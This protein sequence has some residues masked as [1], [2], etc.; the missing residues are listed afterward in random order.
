MKTIFATN[1]IRIILKLL[2]DPTSTRR[3]GLFF[4]RFF[5]AEY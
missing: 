2:S 3:P 5:N 4:L 1:G